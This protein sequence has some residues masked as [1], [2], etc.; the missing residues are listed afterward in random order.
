V[1]Q[2]PFRSPHHTISDA[3]LIGG[4]IAPRTPPVIQRYVAKIFAPRLDRINIHIEVPEVQ[5]KELRGGGGARGDSRARAGGPSALSRRSV[6]EPRANA[7]AS[8]KPRKNLIEPADD[9]ASD[10]RV[11][12]AG[13]GCGAAAGARHAATGTHSAGTRQES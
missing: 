9:D 2:R 3:G 4:A 12:R 7:V 6:A 13:T 1:I 5:V 11:L 8:P 10:S